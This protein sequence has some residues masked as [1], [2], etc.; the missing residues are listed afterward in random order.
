MEEIKP[1][2]PNQPDF[3]E[4]TPQEFQQMLNSWF[5]E[6][7][8]KTDLKSYLKYKLINI[9]KTTMIGKRLKSGPKTNSLAHQALHL[10][11]AE[12]LFQNQCHYSLSLFSSEVNL[13]KILPEISLFF[14]TN[15]IATRGR[16]DK[17]NLVNI[18]EL[19]GISKDSECGQ[20][21]VNLYFGPDSN[22]S[23][24]V[25]LI[26]SIQGEGPR[27]LN[28]IDENLDDYMQKI[29]QILLT[30]N[31]SKQMYNRLLLQIKCCHELRDKEYKNECLKLIH[32]CKRE[33][34]KRQKKIQNCN[35]NREALE[36]ELLVSQQKQQK[37][38]QQLNNQLKEQEVSRQFVKQ[39]ISSNICTLNHC[40]ERC[41][42]LND[43]IKFYQNENQM[44]KI[45]NKKQKQEIQRLILSYNQLKLELSSCQSKIS[46]LTAG[47]DENQDRNL[48][49]PE[50]G[51]RTYNNNGETDSNYSDSL[52][53]D[54]LQE[55][56]RKIKELEQES[57]QVD[58]KCKSF[59]NI[60]K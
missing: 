6:K 31:L 60:I 37:L 17:H 32:K 15:S 47:L 45:E 20:C 53:E 21:V 25:C 58:M 48:R 33:L 42:Y 52:S 3:K 14:D 34:N 9:L 10:I 57:E 36:K 56:R 44:L 49:L 11:I 39:K 8:I 55:A 16:L 13:T 4:L 28:Y 26:D 35:K 18:L 19:L 7:G 51:L 59:M 24:L 30:A 43:C 54:I 50:V 38:N 23:I 5:E 2:V 22:K 1:A 46:I 12:Y 40:S 41:V 29:A 27:I